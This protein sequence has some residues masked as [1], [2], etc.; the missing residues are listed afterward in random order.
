MGVG[1]PIS[2]AVQFALALA[3]YG[4]GRRIPGAPLVGPPENKKFRK[5]K[6][7]EE[8]KAFLQMN[9]EEGFDL[10][11]LNAINLRALAKEAMGDKRISR[12]VLEKVEVLI[13]RIR[14]ETEN[15]ALVGAILRT[16]TLD[17]YRRSPSDS[18]WAQ[19]MMPRW[20]GIFY[21]SKVP[22]G[23]LS[24]K[25]SSRIA[26]LHMECAKPSSLFG[27]ILRSRAN[28]KLLGG[29][30][31]RALQPL[32]SQVAQ[33]YL[34]DLA[35]SRRIGDRPLGLERVSELARQV[36]AP[37]INRTLGELLRHE[38]GGPIVVLDSRYHPDIGT[39]AVR[40]PPPKAVG[41]S[42][43]YDLVHAKTPQA[44]ASAPSDVATSEASP[45]SPWEGPE[46]TKKDWAGLLAS[47]QK[48]KTKLDPP[49]IEDYRKRD[50]YLGLRELVLTDPATRTTFLAVRWKGKPSGLALLAQLLSEGTFLPEAETDGDYLEGELGHIE[51]GDPNYRP[52]GGRWNLGNGWTVVREIA[53]GNERTYR[54]DGTPT[55]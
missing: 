45:S 54:T 22:G 43:T 17:W 47:L 15:A 42:V 9:P 8:L 55:D 46:I 50:A 29:G 12:E 36:G 11:A 38:G 31:K 33:A 4:G 30:S 3:A 25:L 6:K 35:A 14:S 16:K 53:D 37:E 51:K 23:R 7:S 5:I 28:V 52:K 1:P 32:T 34:D 41:E 20:G 26:D 10:E 48:R 21:Q 27:G 18:N 19:R 49:P 40:A 13:P 44:R 39:V 24:P 2:F